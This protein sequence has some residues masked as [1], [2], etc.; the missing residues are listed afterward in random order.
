MLDFRRLTRLK[1]LWI[2]IVLVLVI[3]LCFLAYSY[4]SKPV[5][6]EVNVCSHLSDFDSQTISYLIDLR[7]RW[8]RTD[9]MI[10]ADNSMRN[11]SQIL[12]D[13]NI[14]LL[15]IIDIN[16]FGNQ[17]L[18]L[19]EWNNTVTEVV[20]SEGFNNTDAVEIWNEPNSIAFVQPETY[21]EMLKSAYTIIKNYTAIP[22]VF[23]GVSPN[24]PNWQT[25][26]T[27]VFAYDDVQDYFDYMGI[28]LYDDMA[29]NLNTLQFVKGLTSKQIWLTETGKPT[30]NNDETVQA[31]YLRSIYSTFKPL[32]SKIF[33]YELKD[34]YGASPEKENHF[35]LLTL[36]GTKKEAY[37]V[38]WNI[39]RK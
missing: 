23:A 28:H 21:Y 16:T 5:E 17:S 30:E 39:G 19:E 34:G 8:V 37:E 7:V 20:N 1:T 32:V 38:I 22:V 29:T 2:L 13:N 9:W 36:E 10:T 35:G 6:G 25:Y 33:I 12:Q 24:V 31:E 15:A 14:S 3:G 4:Y 11:Y 26:L 27:A 18:T